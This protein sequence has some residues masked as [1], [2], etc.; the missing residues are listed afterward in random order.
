MI[1]LRILKF[2]F[3]YA[4][5]I[6]VAIALFLVAVCAGIYQEVKKNG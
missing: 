2:T 4:L 5:W 1:V 3:K 6:C